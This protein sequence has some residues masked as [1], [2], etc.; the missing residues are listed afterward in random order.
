MRIYSVV[1]RPTAVYANS[2]EPSV[3]YVAS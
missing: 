3:I 1:R 2:R